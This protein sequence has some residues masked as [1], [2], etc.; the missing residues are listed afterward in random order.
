MCVLGFFIGTTVR[1]LPLLG[2]F[3]ALI[4]KPLL[5]VLLGPI[6][7]L[8][9][10]VLLGALLGTIA[11]LLSLSSLLL[12]KIK[13]YALSFAHSAPQQPPVMRPT[14]HC[15]TNVGLRPECH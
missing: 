12:F 1:L 7:G 2:T 10:S 4:A 3:L 14:S 11:A 6:A 5:G 9:L 8:L 13:N 15:G